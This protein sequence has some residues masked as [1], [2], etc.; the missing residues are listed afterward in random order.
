LTA[1]AAPDTLGSRNTL[2][3]WVEY[4]A[5]RLAIGGLSRMPF[6][7]QRAAANLVAWAGTRFERRHSEPGR[8]YIV[9][10][11]GGELDDQAIEA[12]L[13]ASWRHLTTVV[14]EDAAFN[15]RVL[16]SGRLR[17]HFEVHLSDEVKA[18]RD[19]G[20]GGFFLTPHVG[21]W[22]VMPAIAMALGFRPGFVVARPPKN[23][24]ISRHTQRQR[25]MRGF[26][27]IHPNGAVAGIKTAIDAGGWVGLL[28]DQRARGK[29]VVAPY[30]GKRVRCLRTVPVLVR[31]L[32]RPV[33]FGA[34]YRTE[35]SLHYRLVADRVLW[36]DQ[37]REGDLEGTAALINR[38]LERLIRAAPDQ[39]LWLHDRFRGAPT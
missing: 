9:Q 11:L 16:A 19:Q 39:Y 13:V 1:P 32:G 29:T 18:A 28:L 6:A 20:R 37:L 31:R 23:R 33:I 27:L 22:E 24:P 14:L 12:L 15:R 3:A 30:F 5:Y 38:E 35:R 4:A 2:G 10:A 7:W 26:E 17:D 21:M 8:R 25:E 36:P 34:C